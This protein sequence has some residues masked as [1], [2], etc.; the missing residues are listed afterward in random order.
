MWNSILVIVG[1]FGLWVL[2]HDLTQ[3]IPVL[4]LVILTAI[5][6]TSFKLIIDNGIKYDVLKPLRDRGIVHPFHQAHYDRFLR[7]QAAAD[8]PPNDEWGDDWE[9]ADSPSPFE[10]DDDIDEDDDR[11]W[12]NINFGDTDD[13][14]SD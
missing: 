13:D 6:L 11:R 14:T 12:L 4:Q 10:L 1:I 5:G 8:A 3:G 7:E 9:D 2:M